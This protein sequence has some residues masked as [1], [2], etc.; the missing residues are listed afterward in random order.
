MNNNLNTIQNTVHDLATLINKTSIASGNGVAITECTSF[1]D[2]PEILKNVMSAA[3]TS[4]VTLL[5][6]K[7]SDINPG[8]PSDTGSFD[9]NS[10]EF[11]PPAG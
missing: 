5:I 3:S 1:S 6:Y 10:C 7:I 4:L 9:F 8:I 11:T 2:Y